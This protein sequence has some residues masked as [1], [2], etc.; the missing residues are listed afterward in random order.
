M[1]I[2]QAWNHIAKN[3]RNKYP[4]WGICNE[5]KRCHTHELITFNQYEKMGKK[6]DKYVKSIT[7]GNYLYPIRYHGDWEERLCEQYDLYRAHI[8]SSFANGKTP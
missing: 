6:L 5:L 2:R 8:C 3:F 4:L 1:T 7:P